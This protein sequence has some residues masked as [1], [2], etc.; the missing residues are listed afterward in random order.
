MHALVA[1]GAMEPADF[2]TEHFFVPGM[3]CRVMTMQAGVTFVGKVHK[4]EHF[5]ILAKGEIVITVGDEVTRLKAPHVIASKGGV[6][7]AGHVIENC[8]CIT[9]HKTDKTDLDEI[10]KEVI[11]DDPRALYD[12]R[13]QLKD[14]VLTMNKPEVLS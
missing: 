11:E 12:A 9:V 3:Y 5:F 13:N 6:K 4:F 7:R 10:E 2:P 14:E 8:M 1:S